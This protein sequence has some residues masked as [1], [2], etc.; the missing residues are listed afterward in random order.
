MAHSAQSDFNLVCLRIFRGHLLSLTGH[1]VKL[2]SLWMSTINI[3]TLNAPLSTVGILFSKREGP[4]ACG[5]LASDIVTL[6]QGI[7]PLL[8]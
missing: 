8:L 6:G 3:R 4:I 7:R 2:G 5:L 1:D